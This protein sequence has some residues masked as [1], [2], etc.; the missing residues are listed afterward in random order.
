MILKGTVEHIHAWKETIFLVIATKILLL[1]Y[2][3]QNINAST[4]I[5]SV[6]TI[7]RR[8]RNLFGVSAYV[9]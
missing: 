2:F 8:Q 5:L 1:Y 9:S 7:N 4:T 3:H 6:K